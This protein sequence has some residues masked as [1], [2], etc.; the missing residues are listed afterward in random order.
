MGVQIDECGIRRHSSESFWNVLVFIVL[1]A[2][3]KDQ[4]RGVFALYVALDSGVSG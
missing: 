3:R 2:V 4:A 1:M